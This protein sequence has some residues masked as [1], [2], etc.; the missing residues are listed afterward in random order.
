MPALKE[1]GTATG[2]PRQPESVAISTVR[3]DFNSFRVLGLVLC[4][5]GMD[6]RCLPKRVAYPCVASWFGGFSA[7]EV[8]GLGACTIADMLGEDLSGRFDYLF[9]PLES[10]ESAGNGNDV[11]P[12]APDRVADDGPW[13]RRIVLIGVVLA[14]IAAAVATVV[15][16]LQPAHHTQ[17]IVTPSDSTPPSTTVPTAKSPAMST[18]MPTTTVQPGPV[19]PPT[20]GAVEPHRPPVQEPTTVASEPPPAPMPPPPTTRSPISVSPEPRP[21]FP[22]QSPPRNS[23]QR[24]GLLGGIL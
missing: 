3:H 19:S 10:D 15:V 1:P 12:G 9:E 21:P 11:T 8:G 17:V 14:T 7:V 2:Q 5:H 18:A 24:G 23:D 13:S 22:N 16:L 6:R 20:V 4:K